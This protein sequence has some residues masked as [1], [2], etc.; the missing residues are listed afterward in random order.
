MSLQS[1]NLNKCEPKANISTNTV[2]ILKRIYMIKLSKIALITSLSVATFL[3]FAQTQ[4]WVLMNLLL[5]A[6]AAACL[7]EAD[8]IVADIPSSSA[9]EI[10]S[11]M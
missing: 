10:S 7:A 2:V 4:H 8:V 1:I 9:N 11:S 6:A 3:S 5:A